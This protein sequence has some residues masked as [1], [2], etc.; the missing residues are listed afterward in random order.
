MFFEAACVPQQAPGLQKHFPQFSSISDY[1]PAPN[2]AKPQQSVKKL[3]SMAG[4]LLQALVPHLANS[5]EGY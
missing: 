3:V 4:R 5:W 1:L 2:P